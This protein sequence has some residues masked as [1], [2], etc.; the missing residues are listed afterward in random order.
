MR[1]MAP[2][3][4]TGENS[5][6]IGTLVDITE[7][8]RAEE[9]L[10]ESENKFRSLAEKSFVGVFLVQDNVFKYVNTRFAEIHGYAIEEM[11]DKM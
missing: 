10:R 2:A 3:L 4:C 11:V 7:Q 8:K 9:A 1:S 6:N 5:A